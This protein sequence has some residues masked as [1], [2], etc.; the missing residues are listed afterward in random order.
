MAQSFP[1]VETCV[2]E[3]NIRGLIHYLSFLPT[4]DS[5]RTLQPGELKKH[6]DQFTA[7]CR[8]MADQDLLKIVADADPPTSNRREKHWLDCMLCQAAEENNVVMAQFLIEKCGADV[9]WK[10]S[11][12]LGRAIKK[13]SWEVVKFFAGHAYEEWIYKYLKE[14][15]RDRNWDA[16]RH[17][18]SGAPKCIQIIAMP[19]MKTMKLVYPNAPNCLSEEN[20]PGI[21]HYLDIK[22]G[23]VQYVGLD[24]ARKSPFV[25]SD[26]VDSY[27]FILRSLTKHYRRHLVQA[28][29]GVD[30]PPPLSKDDG[31]YG[32]RDIHWL[33]A[34]L[35][36]AIKEKDLAAVEFLV[37]ECGA[38]VN[39]YYA[40][41]L[42][43]ALRNKTSEIVK[44]LIRHVH[45]KN[46]FK[47]FDWIILEEP[48]PDSVRLLL[49]SAS[50]D[51]LEQLRQDDRVQHMYMDSSMRDILR[52]HGFDL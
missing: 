9:D 11:W 19:M 8:L 2:Q 52:E 17:I 25:W 40:T 51:I 35:L 46:L 16:M 44:F 1:D 42:G 23:F 41:S 21:L 4:F 33:D 34:L 37:N 31:R 48:D 36:E 45:F 24:A 13:R 43:S 10:M 39:F 22:L 12:A 20:I 30:P 28:L 26:Q 32:M 47:N 27:F 3:R 7:R 6:E 14:A 38:D 18:V 15:A 29:L 49:T 50:E 5:T